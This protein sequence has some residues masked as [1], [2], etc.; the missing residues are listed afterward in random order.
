MGIEYP[1]AL[2]A[3]VAAAVPLLLQRRSR[4]AARVVP[5]PNV[6]LLRDAARRSRRE[7][8]LSHAELLAARTLAIAFAALALA[9]PYIGDRPPERRPLAEG[10]VIVLIDGST[11]WRGSCKEVAREV[12]RTERRSGRALLVP[13]DDLPGPVFEGDEAVGLLETHQGTGRTPDVERALMLARR[14]VEREAAPGVPVTVV[15]LAPRK[16]VREALELA[17]AGALFGRAR[18]LAVDTSSSWPAFF[19]GFTIDSVE[20]AH[21]RVPVGST[22]GVTARIRSVYPNRW[23]W[24][25]LKVC[26]YVEDEY[27]HSDE[28]VGVTPLGPFAFR[29][30]EPEEVLVTARRVRARTS[31]LRVEVHEEVREK[32]REFEKG[33]F[34]RSDRRWLVLPEVGPRRVLVVMTPGERAATILRAVRALEAAGSDSSAVQDIAVGTVTPEEIDAGTLDGFDVVVVS[35]TENVPERARFLLSEFVSSGG[36][37][38]TCTG[39]ERPRLVLLDVES[40]HERVRGRT[41]IRPTR[42]AAPW[43]LPGAA[44]AL[45]S[46]RFS[47]YVKFIPGDVETVLVFATGDPAFVRSRWGRGIASLFTADITELASQPSVLLPLLDALLRSLPCPGP[48]IAVDIGDTPLVTAVAP[49]EE[50]KNL[51]LCSPGGRRFDVDFARVARLGEGADAWAALPLNE[52]GLWWI[53]AEREH[54]K[55]GPVETGEAATWTETLRVPVAVN[56]RRSRSPKVLDTMLQS[57]NDRDTLTYGGRSA[58]M[59]DEINAPAP[60]I[61]PEELADALSGRGSPSPAPMFAV[62]ALAVLVAEALLGTRRGPFRVPTADARGRKEAEP[63]DA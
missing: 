36:G 26:L 4:P 19:G 34:Q 25:R 51:K 45:A 57:P 3:L 28:P 58:T 20:L 43:S 29:G 54:R 10:T 12:L 23:D 59:M 33:L 41:S 2:I 8:V 63:G 50:L 44:R 9:A 13:F 37:L 15:L 22:I 42:E 18:F 5:F 14:L 48:G 11:G 47:S 31:L 30:T 21:E 61:Q 32:V 46:A 53:E 49:A 24:P 35:D 6:E 55:V 56:A 60:G 16:V 62:L 27:R 1:A 52:P 39:E 40:A 38:L 7:K 17:A